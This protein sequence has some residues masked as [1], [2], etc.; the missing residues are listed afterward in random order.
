MQNH[1]V[2]VTIP[3]GQK[4]QAIWAQK[5]IGRLLIFVHGF[6]GSSVNTW[7][8]FPSSLQTTSS[9]QGYDAVFY[10]YDSLRT[11]ARA[12]AHVLIQL[13]DALSSEP[14]VVLNNSLPTINR[15]EAFSYRKIVIV[16]HSLGAVVTRIALLDAFRSKRTWVRKVRLLFFA[17][18][19]QGAHI[20]HLATLVMGAL[21]LAPLEALARYRFQSLFDLDEKSQ[22]LIQLA[23]QTKK[24][25]RAGAKTLIAARVV[26]AGDEKIVNPADFCDDPPPEF[27]YGVDHIRICKPHRQFL[28]PLDHLLAVL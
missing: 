3:F 8:E 22:T 11:R 9:L 12:S 16:A 5:P 4:S 1:H 27:I 10:G 14:S 24:A 25:I 28:A 20:L 23:E 7:V 13:L 21:R 2:P 17:P 19:H 6:G 18:A 26:H 15:N